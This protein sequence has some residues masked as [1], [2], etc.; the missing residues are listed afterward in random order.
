MEGV[1]C[2]LYMLSLVGLGSKY[3]CALSNQIFSLLCSILSLHLTL[4]PYQIN[5]KNAQWI[6]RI[7]W[8]YPIL[9]HS[10]G[11]VN[12]AHGRRKMIK[13]MGARRRAAEVQAATRRSGGILSK[14]FFNSPVSFCIL[15]SDFPRVWQKYYDDNPHHSVYTWLVRLESRKI[16][17]SSSATRIDLY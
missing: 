4:T 10:A 9:V 15:G 16:Q 6:P 7:G 1:K 13:V 8:F 17:L 14:E 5:T 2:L 3:I 12:F 11:K